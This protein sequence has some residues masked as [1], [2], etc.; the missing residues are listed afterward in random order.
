[1]NPTTNS[2]AI[3]ETV[4]HA[5]AAPP[6]FALNC[7]PDDAAECQIS[8]PWRKFY[9]NVASAQRWLSDDNAGDRRRAD[10]SLSSAVAH[11]D[12]ADAYGEGT[13]RQQELYRQAV[14]ARRQIRS[15]DHG[16]DHGR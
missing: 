3:D 1:M 7:A 8:R 5:A 6:L 11:V 15:G 4:A 16:L 9:K 14:A 12:N 2:A 13:P 10:V